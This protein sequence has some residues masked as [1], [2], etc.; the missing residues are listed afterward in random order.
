MSHRKYEAPRHGSMGFSPR[1]RSASHRGRVRSFPRDDKSKPP[2]LTAFMGYK[3]GMTHI[4]RE[5]NK[6]GRLLAHLT[7]TAAFSNATNATPKE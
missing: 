6:P 5:V 3:A 1:K 2:H 4:L 7:T